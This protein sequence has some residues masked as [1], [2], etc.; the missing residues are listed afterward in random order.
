MTCLLLVHVG[1][2]LVVVRVHWIPQLIKMIA[3]NGMIYSYIEN[4][5]MAISISHA[6]STPSTSTSILLNCK[7]S[8]T[9][10]ISIVTQYGAH[11]NHIYTCSLET[12]FLARY[13]V[14]YDVRLFLNAFTTSIFNKFDG[15]FF[16]FLMVRGKKLYL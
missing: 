5:Y 10:H 8:K 1:G 9:H 14:K 6:V 7:G 4:K 12:V 15:K 11:Q 2:F 3:M 16:Q 13:S